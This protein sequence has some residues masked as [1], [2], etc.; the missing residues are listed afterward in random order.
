[1]FFVELPL[2]SGKP[3]TLG[4]AGNFTVTT[5]QSNPAHSIISDGVHNNGGWVIAL[6]YSETVGR[7]YTASGGL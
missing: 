4:L 1:M 3:I 6:P 5:S 2:S 7:I